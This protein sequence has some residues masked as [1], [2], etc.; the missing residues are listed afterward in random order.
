M[1]NMADSWT[2]KLRP[3]R[4]DIGPG[5]LEKDVDYFGTPSSHHFIKPTLEKNQILN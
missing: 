3:I 5:L 2:N 1:T 4:Q